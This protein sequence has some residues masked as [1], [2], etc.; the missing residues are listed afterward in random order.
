MYIVMFKVLEKSRQ[1]K[2]ILIWKVSKYS[3]YLEVLHK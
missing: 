1:E 2:K 3:P